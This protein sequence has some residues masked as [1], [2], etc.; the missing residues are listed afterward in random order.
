MLDINQSAI[1]NVDNLEKSRCRG[2]RKVFSIVVLATVKPLSQ[3]RVSGLEGSFF[4]PLEK[5][6]EKFRFS[7]C[8]SGGSCSTSKICE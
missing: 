3:R 4:A 1:V 5:L 6:K 8:S 7:I 2:S